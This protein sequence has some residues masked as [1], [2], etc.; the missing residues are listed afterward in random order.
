MAP[1]K[2]ARVYSFDMI[3]SLIARPVGL[4]LTGPARSWST[5]GPGSWWWEP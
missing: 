1:G 2:L 4:G 3:G 5:S